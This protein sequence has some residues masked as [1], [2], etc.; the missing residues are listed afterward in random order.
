MDILRAAFT[1]AE[2][3]DR[4]M[5]TFPDMYS[6]LSVTRW[7]A[8]NYGDPFWILWTDAAVER[9][10]HLT[11][12]YGF[13]MSGDA[14]VIG[15]GK[16][17]IG[18]QCIERVDIYSDLPRL[19][20]LLPIDNRILISF[21]IN[22]LEIYEYSL[23]KVVEMLIEHEKGVMVT[24]LLGSVIEEL[25]P[26]HDTIVE[27][28]VG[29]DSYISFHNYVAKLRFSMKGGLAVVSDQFIMKDSDIAND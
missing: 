15:S 28:E 24:A 21:G 12:K 29:E 8:E 14:L 11:K 22:F 16:E 4:I 2:E 5:I 6:F 27:I 9:I 26:F 18:L 13:P 25:T 23:S 19:M 10:N 17:C 20:K 3:G 7:I 1:I